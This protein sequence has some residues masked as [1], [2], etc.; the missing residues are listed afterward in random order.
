M[1]ITRGKMSFDETIEALIKEAQARGEFDNL[2]GKGKP[3]DLAEY[4]NTPQD[5][6][7]AQAMLK[8]AGMVPVEI[9]LL[10]EIAA[11]KESLASAGDDAEINRIR[12]QL[13]EKQ[14]QFDLLLERRKR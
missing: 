10:Q 2:P 5:V 7:V 3:I 13:K 1:V 14:L 8:N 4:F 12:K 6:R 11:L 9:E